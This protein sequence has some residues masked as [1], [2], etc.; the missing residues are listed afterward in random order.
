MIDNGK[1]I[2]LVFRSVVFNLILI[3]SVRET[4]Q[5]AEAQQD[6]NARLREAFGISSSFVEG[7]SLQ[8]GR[9]GPGAMPPPP[10][11]VY[12]PVRTPSP[13]IEVPAKKKKSKHSR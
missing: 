10:P 4:H 9:R 3:F 5:L 1:K 13:E 12:Q 11:P 7:T 8:S 2:L 6:K